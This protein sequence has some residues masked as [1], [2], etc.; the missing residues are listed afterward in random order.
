MNKLAILARQR[1]RDC[2][3]ETGL[4]GVLS[5][6]QRQVRGSSEAICNP[7]GKLLP[8]H[9]A[10]LIALAAHRLDTLRRA[11]IVMQLAAQL[12]NAAVNGAIEAVE[13]DASQLPHQV[14]AAHHF[15]C[16]TY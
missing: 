11:G 8:C 16:T 12:G 1:A 3:F 14:I 9:L 10:E 6:I 7:V 5:A 2:R 13:L 15:A 4:C